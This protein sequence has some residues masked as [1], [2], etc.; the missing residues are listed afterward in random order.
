MDST[1]AGSGEDAQR[2]VT[3]FAKATFYS[4]QDNLFMLMEQVILLYKSQP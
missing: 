2:R 4:K 1:P 3:S